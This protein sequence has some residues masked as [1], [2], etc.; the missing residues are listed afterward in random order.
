MTIIDIDINM[1]KITYKQVIILSETNLSN[2]YRAIDDAIL[3]SLDYPCL[4]F[5]CICGNLQTTWPAINPTKIEKEFSAFCTVFKLLSLAEQIHSVAK[6]EFTKE[7]FINGSFFMYV[8]L[9]REELFFFSTL[10]DLGLCLINFSDEDKKFFSG[11]FVY[12]NF[13]KTIKSPKKKIKEREN[14]E[15]EYV[16]K[17]K[18]SLENFFHTP[19]P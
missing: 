9:V 10:A 1:P 4:S 11:D 18:A 14:S 12:E 13:S 16:D 2:I 8:L 5:R 17:I 19:Q 7:S 15:M 6:V 3:F